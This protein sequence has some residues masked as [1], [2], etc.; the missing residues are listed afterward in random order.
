M[1]PAARERGT[2]AA[3]R[4]GANALAASERLRVRC[5]N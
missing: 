2:Q 5:V 1:N 4:G 3:A